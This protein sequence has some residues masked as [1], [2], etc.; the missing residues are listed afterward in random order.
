MKKYKYD[1]LT[2]PYVQP[3]KTIKA[4]ASRYAQDIQGSVN[5]HTQ[6]VVHCLSCNRCPEQFIGETEKSLAQRFRQHRGFVRNKTLDKATGHHF[7]QPGQILVALRIAVMEK[8]YSKDPW[9]RRLEDNRQCGQSSVRTIVSADNCQGTFVREDI[10][11]RTIISKHIMLG[12]LERSGLGDFES[13]IYSG[14][15]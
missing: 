5:C 4:T 15:L 11:P 13:S 6:N 2:C 14:G 1:C 12:S 8:V 10:C 9:M 3:S 7:N